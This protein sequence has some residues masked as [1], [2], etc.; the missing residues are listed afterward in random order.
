MWMVSN[1]WLTIA[2][3]RGRGNEGVFSLEMRIEESGRMEGRRH[4]HEIYLRRRV[5]ERLL[6]LQD[7]CNDEVAY[8]AL[9]MQESN[10]ILLTWINYYEEGPWYTEKYRKDQKTS[11]N[12]QTASARIFT[13]GTEE[14]SAGAMLPWVDGPQ[15]QLKKHTNKQI[16]QIHTNKLDKHRKAQTNQTPNTKRFTSTTPMLPSICSI[17]MI[18]LGFLQMKYTPMLFSISWILSMKK[19]RALSRATCGTNEFLVQISGKP[20][21]TRRREILCASENGNQ[22]VETRTIRSKTIWSQFL[23]FDHF[24]SIEFVA[25]L[26]RP[27]EMERTR[28]TRPRGLWQS[29]QWSSGSWAAVQRMWM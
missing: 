21:T 22:G 24:F 8:T 9:Y 13:L 2:I 26:G 27:P 1:G 11:N 29:L 12:S 15:K 19:L 20:P 5:I 10:E 16:R 14:G 18:L 4:E 17:W 7:V 3:S 25:N 28:C 23:H 6:Q